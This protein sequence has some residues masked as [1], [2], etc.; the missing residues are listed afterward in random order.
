MPRFVL[1]QTPERARPDLGTAAAI[2]DIDST[3][4]FVINTSPL[5]LRVP[6]KLQEGGAVPSF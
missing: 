2:K 4:L 1:G 3:P 5:F 6:R